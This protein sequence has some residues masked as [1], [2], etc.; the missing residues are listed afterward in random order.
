MGKKK[1]G[2]TSHTLSLPRKSSRASSFCNAHIRSKGKN[3]VFPLILPPSTRG[4]YFANDE[5]NLKY[6]PLNTR[7]T[8]EQKY[9]HVESLR[10]LRIVDD[11]GTLLGNLGWLD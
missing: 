2:E 9:F 3:D 10:A 11:M 1:D 6:E 7:N 8:S 4:S 5:Q